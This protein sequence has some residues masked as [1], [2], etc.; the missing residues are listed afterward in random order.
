MLL[1]G[2]VTTTTFTQLATTTSL[3]PTMTDANG[4]HEELNEDDL[5]DYEEEDVAPTSAPEAAKATET[6][7]TT[8]KYAFYQVSTPPR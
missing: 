5:V 8:K 6:G 7:V 4:K 1:G 3:S 2:Q